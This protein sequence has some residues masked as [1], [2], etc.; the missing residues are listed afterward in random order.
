MAIWKHEMCFVCSQD[1]LLK[2][3]LGLSSDLSLGPEAHGTI[4]TRS[5]ILRRRSQHSV[6]AESVLTVGEMLLRLYVL[7]PFVHSLKGSSFADFSLVYFP[8]I[9]MCTC[10]CFQRCFTLVCFADNV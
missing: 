9:N 4:I 6:G 8:T 1:G 2:C 3:I 7:V 10:K 5:T